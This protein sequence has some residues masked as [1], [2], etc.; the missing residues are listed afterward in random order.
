MAPSENEVDTPGLSNAKELSL[1]TFD[2]M[3]ES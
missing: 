2:N 1:D 3:E